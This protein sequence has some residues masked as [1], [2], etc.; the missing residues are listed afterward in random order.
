MPIL[1]NS[2]K[3]KI[4]RVRLEFST[5]RCNCPLWIAITV[6]QV[7]PCDSSLVNQS[8]QEIFAKAGGMRRRQAHVFVQMKNFNMAPID[9]GR[10]GQCIQELK[11]RRP[12]GSH[13]AG[14]SLIA[15]RA[16]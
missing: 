16:P 2:G 10:A 11:L 1:S 15:K 14:A 8:L 12:S 7:I 13:D 9:T 3:E 4:H 5:N 6:Q